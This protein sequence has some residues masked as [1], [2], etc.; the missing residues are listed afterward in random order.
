[1]PPS[2]EGLARLE[3]DGE[4]HV[5]L[6]PN[7]P[8]YS[9][10]IAQTNRVRL[11]AAL[12]AQW[13]GADFLFDRGRRAP[14]LRTIK[15]S[16]NEFTTA[17]GP[18]Y[19]MN[20]TG[21]KLLGSGGRVVAYPQASYDPVGQQ[22]GMVSQITRLWEDADSLR[23]YRPIFLLRGNG[24]KLGE[25]QINGRR[26]IFGNTF[27][28]GDRATAGIECEGRAA[29]FGP[30]SGFHHFYDLTI[31]EC[32]AGISALGGY[33]TNVDGDLIFNQ[34][35]QNCDQCSV[36]RVSFSAVTDCFRSNNEQAV[37]WAFN[38]I[39]VNQVDDEDINVFNIIRGG[40][41]TANTVIL[42]HRRVYLYRQGTNL[43]YSSCSWIN[44]VKWDLGVDAPGTFLCLYKWDG[45]VEND[46]SGY[47]ANLEI[48]GHWPRQDG[49]DATKIIQVP[50]GKNFPLSGI[51]VKMIDMP[52][53]DGQWIDIGGGFFTPNPA[54]W[55]S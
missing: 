42:N 23:T 25:L 6:V 8:T 4:Y 41:I 2:R 10:S 11:S 7:D 38:T 22:G 47:H 45:Q 18:V 20:R 34:Y 33:Y 24:Q 54:Y 40:N 39:H 26:W 12:N 1:M 27:A 14:I 49:F 53:P 37:G 16:G 52:R 30:P 15:L 21:G 36:D 19:T 3:Y 44:G 13:R 43:P 51:R 29:E 9:I 46:M 35:E 28:D 17:S 55:A 50:R 31:Q 5:G 48:T 32:E